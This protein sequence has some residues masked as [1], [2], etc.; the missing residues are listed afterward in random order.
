MVQISGQGNSHLRGG[1]GHI[2]EDVQV[3]EEKANHLLATVGRHTAQGVK[4]ND[5]GSVKRRREHQ[6]MDIIAAHCDHGGCIEKV[7][8]TL[9]PLLVI[10]G[11]QHLSI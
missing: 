8:H 10:A 11:Q 9:T 2:P 1:R 7:T 6:P 5:L 4:V 3:G